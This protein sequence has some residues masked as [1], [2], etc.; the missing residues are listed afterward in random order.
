[1]ALLIVLITLMILGTMTADLMETN[2]VYL[3]T[4]VNARDTVRAEYLARSGIN[5]ARLMLSFQK[6]LGSSMNFPFW[7]Y[8]D[9]VV[10][11]FTGE[12]GGMLSDMAGLDLSTV[13]GLGL[14]IEDSD[15][16]VTVVDEDSKININMA[17]SQ[18][19]AKMREHMMSQL[20][21]LVAPPEYD[22]LF[23]RG[24]KGKPLEREAG[25]VRNPGLV[26]SR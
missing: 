16:K 10:E 22:M 20:M 25:R 5:L 8:T 14:G 1:M 2:E 12:G 13:E 11:I 21:A 24:V 15:L 18:G 17:N 9:Y 7:Q 3:A 6:I 4:T 26:R 19:R 23:E